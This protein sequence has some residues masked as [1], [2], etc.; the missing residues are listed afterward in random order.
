MTN[1]AAGMWTIT[2][3]RFRRSRLAVIAL[4]YV[5]FVA[6]LALAAPMIANSSKSLIP[7]TPSVCMMMVRGSSEHI[8]SYHMWPLPLA[9][10]GLLV[11]SAFA[12]ILTISPTEEG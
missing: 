9:R 7:F 6:L 2:W 4:V 10:T 8:V 5:G 3:R 12:T 1:A 11:F